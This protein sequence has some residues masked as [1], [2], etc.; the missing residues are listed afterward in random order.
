MSKMTVYL[1]G[2]IRG[3]SY[4]EAISWRLAAEERLSDVGMRCLSPM[5][6]KEL[7]KDEE[8]ITDSYEDLKGYSSKDIF[9]RDKFDVSRSDILLFNFT[10]RKVSIIGSLF[11]LAWGHLLG[12]YCVVAVDKESIYAKHPF[13]KESASIMFENIEEAIDYVAKCFGK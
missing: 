9:S 1:G 6:G 2:P 7:I 8:K 4:F 3:L 11:E 10:N 13:V 5:R 12:K